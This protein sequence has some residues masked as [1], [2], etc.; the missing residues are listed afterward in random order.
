M[1]K[2]QWKTST[3]N[4]QQKR[5]RLQHDEYKNQNENENPIVEINIYLYIFF[6]V[7]TFTAVIH[8]S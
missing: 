2:K 1:N 3:M 6:V 8:F 7:D 5:E 4:T